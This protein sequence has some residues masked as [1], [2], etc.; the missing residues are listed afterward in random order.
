M[1]MCVRVCVMWQEVPEAKSLESKDSL[2]LGSLGSVGVAWI[3]ISYEQEDMDSDFEE[4][5]MD[6]VTPSG[7]MGLSQSTRSSPLSLPL[8][9]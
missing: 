2:G 5:M 4:E 7:S 3:D 1:D 8:P 6:S 9:A